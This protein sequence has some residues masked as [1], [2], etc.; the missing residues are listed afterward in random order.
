MIP[1]FE[2]DAKA[3]NEPFPRFH[4]R[5]KEGMPCSPLQRTIEEGERPIPSFEGDVKAG[6]E[7]FPALTI[8]E[9]KGIAHSPVL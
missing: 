8:S 5:K 7:P 4:G 3:G 1:S 6:N 9:K 2:R